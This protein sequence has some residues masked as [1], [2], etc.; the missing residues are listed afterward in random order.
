VPPPPKLLAQ[1]RT[2][3][4]LR[5]Y[6]RK[7][8]AVYVGWVRRYVRFH[9][10]RHPAALNERAVVAFLGHLA[11]RDRVSAATQSQALS[12]LL[13]LYR[14]V[15][16][17]P[18]ADLPLV[19]RPKRPA[20]LPVVLTPTEVARVLE[21]LDG[22]P[23]LVATLLYGCGLR[24]EEALTLR[25]KDVD[26]EA[27]HLAVRRGKGAKDRMTL[28]PEDVVPALLAHLE[29]VRVRFEADRQLGVGP[30]AL[31]HALARKFPQVG[32]AWVWQWMFPARRLQHD[33]IERLWRRHH[34]HPTVIQRAVTAAVRRAGLTK[35]A[36]CHTFRHSF[37][38]HLLD[39]GYDLRT[40]QELLGHRDVR[41]TMIYTHV[42]ARGPL[43]VVSPVDRLGLSGGAGG[44]PN[45]GPSGGARAIVVVSPPSGAVE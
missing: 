34:L 40:V 14:H 12:A 3:L 16:G 9:G 26:F 42:L 10:L 27:R 37:A 1:L 22:V 17:R 31:P 23:R 7:T 8:E 45:D 39:A 19:V 33:P 43:G 21:A 41:T 29:R 5:H 20:R 25:I 32:R 6:S 11:D 15:L 30:V 36:S 18:L 44:R 28:L 24:L 2:A 35:R 4:R 13:F 38:T